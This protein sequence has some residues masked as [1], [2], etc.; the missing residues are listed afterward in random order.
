M[1]ELTD[2]ILHSVC[3]HLPFHQECERISFC[4]HP[5]QHLLFVDF[6]MITI[7]TGVS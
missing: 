5:L 6:L 4:L 7:L 2:T 1:T 3:V